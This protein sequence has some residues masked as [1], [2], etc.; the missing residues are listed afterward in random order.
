[1]RGGGA[2]EVDQAL[3]AA[4]LTL[5]TL[6]AVLRAE[7]VARRSDE[8]QA[9]Y[10]DAERGDGDGD[11]LDVTDALQRRLLADAGG[12]AP[13]RMAAAL[14]APRVAGEL[15]PSLAPLSLY[16][17]HN[18][19]AAGTLREGDAPVDVPLY[20]GGRRRADVAP[21][22]VRRRR[23]AVARRR[24]QTRTAAAR[25]RGRRLR[26]L[27]AEVAGR[28]HVRLVYIA[29]AH[30]ADVWPI[31]STRYGGPANGVTTPTTCSPSA[32]PPRAR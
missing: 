24:G 9:A 6:E 18:R 21:R 16:R 23:A 26:S 31:N 12:V 2:V 19:A 13:E 22:G 20:L 15:F 14:F 27:A 1:M 29:E 8:V 32:A 10:G 11:W 4:G 28:A 3:A 17:R 25:P 30:A 5:E 7:E